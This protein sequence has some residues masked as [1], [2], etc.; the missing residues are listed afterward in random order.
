MGTAGY[1]GSA[2][3]MI[4][5]VVVTLA[6]L[7]TY[8][9]YAARAKISEL[10]LLGARYK[11]KMDD[12]YVANKRLPAKIE[13]IGGFSGPAGKVKSI[14]LEK[15]A[16]IRV[17]AGFAPVEGRSMLIIPSVRDGRLVW[18]CRSDDIPN[19]CLPAEC[20]K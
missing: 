18:S 8:A 5:V 11:S 16:A 12:F 1:W 7:S 10:I 15:D 13:E 4:G 6:T 19:A 20:R 17:V 9:D 3:M 14:T 2:A